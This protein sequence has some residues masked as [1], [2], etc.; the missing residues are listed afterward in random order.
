MSW[1]WFS[2][3]ASN[4]TSKSQASSPDFLTRDI[5]MSNPS[6]GRLAS[7]LRSTASSAPKSSRAAVNISPLRP[8]L[9]SKYNVRLFIFYSFAPSARRLIWVAK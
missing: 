2:C 5:L 6:S 4:T 7:A 9:H 1:S 8:E 3:A